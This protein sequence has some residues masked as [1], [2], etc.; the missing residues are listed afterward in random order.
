MPVLAPPDIQPV[1]PNLTAKKLIARA[2]RVLGVLPAGEQMTAEQL[3]DHLET[4]NHLLDSWNTER[5]LVYQVERVTFDLTGGTATYSYGDGGDFND[6]RPAK[7]QSAGIIASGTTSERE[8]EVLGASGWADVVDKGLSGAPTAVYDD[9]SVPR[10]NMTFWPKPTDADTAVFYAWKPLTQIAAGNVNAPLTL[11]S[12]YAR[13][14]AFNLALDLAPEYPGAGSP[15]L[16]GIAQQA[17]AGIMKINDEPARMRCDDAMM[18]Y[19]GTYT[20]DITSGRLY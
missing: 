20:G 8:I 4:L 1:L 12:G 14:L 5:L 7:I 15:L 2:L 16:V 9:G 13:A 10:R 19:S 3:D 6:E 17:K 11:P 18:D